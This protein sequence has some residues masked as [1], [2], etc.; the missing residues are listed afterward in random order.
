MMRLARQFVK[1]LILLPNCSTSGLTMKEKQH[2]SFR[3][4]IPVRPAGAIAK[5]HVSALMKYRYEN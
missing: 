3:Q 1:E 4:I 2:Q 5:R